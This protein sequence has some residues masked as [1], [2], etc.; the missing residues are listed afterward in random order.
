MSLPVWVRTDAPYC[1][2][3]ES[4]R[5]AMRKMSQ[6]DCESL[7][8]C[9]GDRKLLGTISMRAVCRYADATGRR[10]AGIRV[11][12]A[13][14]PDTSTC[15]ADDGPRDVMSRMSESRQW[16]LPMIDG[17]KA[18][19]GTV[20]YRLLQRV[21]EGDPDTLRIVPPGAGDE[22][23]LASESDFRGWTL[24]VASMELVSPTGERRHLSRSEL[25]LL[26]LLAQNAGTVMKRDALTHRVCNRTWDSS[27]RYIDVLIG[28]LR[29]K[30]GERASGARVILTV[31][32][33]G[34]LFTLRVPENPAN[35]ANPATPEDAVVGRNSAL[36]VDL[37]DV[38]RV[39]ETAGEIGA[40]DLC[41]ENRVIASV[42][43]SCSRVFRIVDSQGAPGGLSHGWCSTRCAEL[44]IARANAG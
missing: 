9:D 8:V 12:E 11:G 31:Q 25:K 4:V 37:D 36:T 3:D 18:L 40:Q 39:Y 44:G 15:V 7:P 14:E 41:A 2:P 29:G 26:L 38:R 6:W 33:E 32:N 43:M 24:G 10:V 35:P 21:V 42:C 22:A 13:L 5:E 28:N 23:R 30:F 20:R 34:Y 19:I 16:C 27:D 1:R 17:S